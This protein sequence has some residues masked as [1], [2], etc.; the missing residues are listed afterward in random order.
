M[1]GEPQIE[2]LQAEAAGSV[3]QA[4][5]AGSVAICPR[6]AIPGEAWLCL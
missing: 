6:K 4:E 5:A 1:R 3:A 2:G